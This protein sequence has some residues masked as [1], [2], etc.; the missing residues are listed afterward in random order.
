MNCCLRLTAARRT[1]P[2]FTLKYDRGHIRQ[3]MRLAVKTT[4][5]LQPCATPHPQR[6]PG[7]YLVAATTSFLWAVA[8][9][10]AYFS[11]A[12]QKRNQR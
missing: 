3:F 2:N 6:D 10:P 4:C 1:G 9:T 7:E 12:L 8:L 5:L 11:L